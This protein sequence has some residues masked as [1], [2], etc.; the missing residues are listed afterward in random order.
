M[1]AG[2]SA[3]LQAALGVQR[4][5]KR[6]SVL[7]AIVV[8]CGHPVPGTA[9]VPALPAPGITHGRPRP[10]AVGAGGGGDDGGV[11]AALLPVGTEAVRRSPSHPSPRA[12]GSI[13][14]YLLQQHALC[15]LPPGQK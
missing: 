1:S 15:E 12:A 11:P 4:S 3:E 10:S 6:G 2:R 5:S 13:R 14:S 8:G 7:R 9:T